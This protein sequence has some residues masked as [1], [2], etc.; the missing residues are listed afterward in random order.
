MS[1]SLGVKKGSG[2]IWAGLGSD[3]IEQIERKRLIALRK[4]VSGKPRSEEVR[5]KISATWRRNQKSRG[6]PF[7]PYFNVALT[8]GTDGSW[9]IWNNVSQRRERHARLVRSSMGKFP[10]DFRYTT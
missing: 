4:A 7:S 1:R 6:V 9:H 10:K 3:R 2:S 5:R 8:V